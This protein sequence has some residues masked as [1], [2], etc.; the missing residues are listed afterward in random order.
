LITNELARQEQL[1]KDGKFKETAGD[2]MERGGYHEVLTV[3]TE[4]VGEVARA[5]N[6]NQPLV[7]LRAE[8]VQVAAVAVGAIV[9]LD[10]LMLRQASAI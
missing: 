5:L 9:G 7:E 4:E 3:L 6:D 2:M 10:K 8:L 1:K